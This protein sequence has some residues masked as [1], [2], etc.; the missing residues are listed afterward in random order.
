M[1]IATLP[2][3]EE[4]FKQAA[5]ELIAVFEG[6][7]SAPY[8]DTNEKKLLTVGHGFNLEDRATLLAVLNE[9]FK[10]NLNDKSDL[11]RTFVQITTSNEFS[12]AEKRQLLDEKIAEA[13]KN[14]ES[15]FT[16]FTLQEAQSSNV[17]KILL[18]SF[19]TT[20]NSKLSTEELDFSTERAALV[21]LAY[22]SPSLLGDKLINAIKAGNRA[23]AW[24]E[25]RYNSNGNVE[26]SNR[27]Y[28]ESA[29]FG[30]Y[31]DASNVSASEAQDIISFLTANNNAALEQIHK[32]EN[33]DNSLGLHHA[34][35]PSYSMAA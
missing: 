29:L 19:I 25:V 30:L 35:C 4:Q 33:A 15:K 14:N 34:Y 7:K 17:L 13:S 20:V 18:E 9:G 28:I 8:E 2:I 1:A 6:F 24:F 21:S 26:A 5:L 23:A 16:S 10:L 3:T 22:N 27:R 11:F 12:L 31:R 32:E